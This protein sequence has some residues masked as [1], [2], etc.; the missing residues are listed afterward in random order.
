MK[1]KNLLTSLAIILST[2]TFIHADIEIDV[3][4]GA[5][6]IGPKTIQMCIEDAYIHF[7]SIGSSNNTDGELPTWTVADDTYAYGD[8]F[9]FVP[10]AITAATYTVRLYDGMVTNDTVD[11]QGRLVDD[12]ADEIAVNVISCQ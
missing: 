2:T 7:E 12:E 8:T 11:N 3:V 10:P 5:T 6:S 9:Y 4:S 1:T